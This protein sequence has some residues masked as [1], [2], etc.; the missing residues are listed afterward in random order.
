MGR[1][2]AEEYVSK[3][4]ARPAATTI[5][6]VQ[7]AKNHREPLAASLIQLF[8]DASGNNSTRSGVNMLTYA[9]L[10]FAIA[11][12]GGLILASSVLRGKFAPWSVSLLHA[13]L[14]AAGL[15]LV[16]LAILQGT[17]GV[18]TAAFVIFFIAALGGFYL[19]FVHLRKKIPPKGVVVIHAVL[20]VTGFLIL[21]GNV[22][23]LI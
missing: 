12:L 13:G 1:S 8:T 20:A 7:Q 3:A 6:N 18:V 14:G 10:V 22:F 17:A 19:A 9:V 4:G 2:R 5:V 16:L 23:N 15:I 21:A 11:A